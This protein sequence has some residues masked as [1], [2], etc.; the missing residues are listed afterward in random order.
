M[1]K[2]LQVVHEALPKMSLIASD[3][4][5]L[6]DVRIPGE[7]A[8]LVS[9]KVHP[10]SV[11][12]VMLPMLFYSI[13]SYPWT[14][15]VLRTLNWTMATCHASIMRRLTSGNILFVADIIF[16]CCFSWF[17]CCMHD[18]CASFNFSMNYTNHV[19]IGFH[20]NVLWLE[21]LKG[22]IGLVS[23]SSVKDAVCREK[24]ARNEVVRR[25]AMVGKKKTEM[26]WTYAGIQ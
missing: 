7:R 16:R 22:Q 26:P 13:T 11:L 1:Q 21:P 8:P 15:L 5:Y 9:T 20:I 10:V 12:C 2:L 17:S 14:V 19:L 6:P 24:R 4:S 25:N 3:F 18:H 23:L